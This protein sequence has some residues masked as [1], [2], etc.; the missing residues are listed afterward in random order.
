MLNQAFYLYLS[1]SLIANLLGGF[2]LFLKK[3]WSVRKLSG[4]LSLSSGILLSITIFELI[5]E[6]IQ[7]SHFSSLFICIGFLF[8][9]LIQKVLSKRRFYQNEKVAVF[10]SSLLGIFIHSLFE[11]MIIFSSF[12]LNQYVGSLILL[13]SMIHKFLD[14]FL[15]YFM[16][17]YFYQDKKKALLSVLFLI[18][19]T[20]F[21]TNIALFFSESILLNESTIYAFAL[22]ITSGIFLYIPIVD[23]IPKTNLDQN[24]FNRLFLFIGIC[25]IPLLNIWFH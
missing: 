7:L 6:T 24:H 18:L 12:L 23:L 22:S 1:L 10:L 3:D 13:G 20:L 4:F 25:I 17:F 16:T 15:V 19:A 2:I 11:G 9:F 21:G 8:L 14:G 5:P